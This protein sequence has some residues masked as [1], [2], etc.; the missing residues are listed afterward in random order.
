MFAALSAEQT[1]CMSLP[2]EERHQICVSKAPPS[3]RKDSR[4]QEFRRGIIARIRLLPARRRREIR[5]KDKENAKT[6][7]A[8][9]CCQWTRTRRPWLSGWN[10]VFGASGPCGRLFVA[11]RTTKAHDENNQHKVGDE[12]SIQ[13]ARPISKDKRWTVVWAVKA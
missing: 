9:H 5:P 10:V 7:S 12:V 13:N 2:T 4:V 8:G 3:A 1:Q 11:P 6:H